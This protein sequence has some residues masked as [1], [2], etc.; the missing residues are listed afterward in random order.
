MWVWLTSGGGRILAFTYDDPT[1]GPSAKGAY[2][3][4]PPTPEQLHDVLHDPNTTYRGPFESTPVT[5][6]AKL[7]LPDE[8]PWIVW[9]QTKKR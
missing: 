2:A 1:A 9:F 5:D 3:S 6:P 7:G 8:P 4:D